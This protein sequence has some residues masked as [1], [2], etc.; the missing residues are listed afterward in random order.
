[1]V[2]SLITFNENENIYASETNQNN[3][4]LL[5]KI[6]DNAAQLTTY[7]EGEVSSIQSNVA[8]VQATLQANIDQLSALLAKNI[9]YITQV[10]ISGTTGLLVFSNK[11]TVQWGR[12]VDAAEN[13]EIYVKLPKALAN[14]NG[15]VIASSM[16][17]AK[18]Q[19]KWDRGTVGGWFVNSSQICVSRGR[20]GGT[21]QWIVI[22]IHA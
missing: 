21:V 20:G 18:T 13:A 10:S 17:P 14:T 5:S 7:L 19:D 16:T 12:C 3:Q 11:L 6:S 8:S 2:D 4:F 1:M 15:V 22:G 9:A